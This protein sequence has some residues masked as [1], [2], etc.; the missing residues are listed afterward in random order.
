MF[1]TQ[2]DTDKKGRKHTHIFLTQ[3]DTAIIK[4]TPRRNGEVI[5][6]SGVSKCMFKIEDENKK[7]ILA[8]PFEPN[9]GIFSV[10]LE[11]E[12][13]TLFPVETLTYEIEYTFIDGTVNTP[14]RWKF[15]VDE[16][17]SN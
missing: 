7:G 2:I 16:Q 1:Y 8:K 12:E 4:S 17:N 11:S 6:I 3:G 9:E 13:T 10:R 14:N 15:D 5:D